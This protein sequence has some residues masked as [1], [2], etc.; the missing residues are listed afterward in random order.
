MTHTVENSVRTASVHCLTHSH[1]ILSRPHA[2]LLRFHLGILL[3]SVAYL[4]KI[5]QALFKV[6]FPSSDQRVLIE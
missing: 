6:C 1:F 4:P 3:K 5:Y 2:A